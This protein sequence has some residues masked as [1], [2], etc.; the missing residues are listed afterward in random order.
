MY[1]TIRGVCRHGQ[2]IP[3]EPVKYDSSEEVDVII[4]FL[5]PEKDAG[6]SEPLTSE[7]EILYTMGQ[8][9]ANGRFSDASVCHDRYLYGDRPGK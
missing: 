8:R 9:A 7:D 5:D 4:T 2:I 3:A 6:K 1:Y